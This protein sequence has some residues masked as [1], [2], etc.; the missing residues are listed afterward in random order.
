M[1]FKGIVLAGGRSSRFGEDKALAR[2]R[3]TRMI[4]K[5]IRLLEALDLEPTVITSA[6]RDY[7]FLRC[8]IERDLIPNK[9]PLGGIYTAC[10]LFKDYALLILVC[11][12]PLLT[13]P[14]LRMLMENHHEQQWVTVFDDPQGRIQPFPGIYESNLSSLI[15]EQ[16][17]T[18]RLSAGEFLK[19]ISKLKMMGSCFNT[20]VFSNVNEKKDIRQTS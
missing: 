3:G 1:K 14:V 16:I 15:F 6:A 2:V 19:S 12:M 5:A 9:G 17:Q 20:E 8:R 13:K 18:D 10:C 7:S 11:D 4:E